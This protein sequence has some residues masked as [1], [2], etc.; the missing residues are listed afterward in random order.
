MLRHVEQLFTS[1]ERII[2]KEIKAIPDGIYRGQSIAYYDGVREGSEMTIKLAVSIEGDEVTFDFTGS[3]EQTP[4]F[5][6]APYSATASAVMLTFLM[7]LN[8][9]IAHNDGLHRPLKIVNPVGSF[10][11]A[12]Y[13]AA[14]TFGNS[15]TG[16]TCDAI[17][18]AFAGALPDMV[19]AG[20]NRSLNF[21]IVGKDPRHE[22]KNYVDILFL[23]LKG[24]SGA[25]KNCDGFDHIGLINCAGGLQDQDYEMFEIQDPHQ[26]L[27]H[28]FLAHSAG[29]GKG[30][31][32][33]LRRTDFGRSG[34]NRLWRG[35]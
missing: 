19:S 14:T 18:R 16:P 17:F 4:G 3:S 25:T 32:R 9:D 1:T 28:E 15:I 6:N 30:R 2:R 13:P 27:K 10:L 35:C 7:L 34:K 11:N 29:P 20:W 26:L 8:P 24:G 12:A 22:M 33:D 5:V 23:A 21:V 31:R